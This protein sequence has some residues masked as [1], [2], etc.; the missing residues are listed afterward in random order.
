MNWTRILPSAP[1]GKR[2]MPRGG[3]MDGYFYILSG[4][5]G[6]FTVY[7]DTWRS[8]DGIHWEKMS[9]NTGWG[10]RCYPEVELIDGNII[11]IAGQSLNQ[12]YN[13][14][15]RSSD[16]GKTWKQVCA[17]APWG[18]RAGHHTIT[19]KKEIYLFGGARNS[20]DRIFYPELWVSKDLGETWELRAHLPTDMGRAGMQVVYI[21]GVIYF[22][23]GDHDKPVFLPN[24]AGRRNDIW[25]STDLGKTWQLIGHAPWS[26]RTGQQ[27]IA[28]NGKVICIGG[29]IQGQYK[30]KQ[31]LAHD[32][33]V[34]NPKNGIDDWKLISN[35]V[36]SAETNT[37]ASG[38]SDFLLEI[39]DNKIWTLGGDR[40]VISPY[41]QDNDVWVANLPTEIL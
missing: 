34:W 28:H 13:D 38:K 30:Y 20:R 18:V 29:H 36:W 33:W 12:F 27:C 9:A 32:L 21:D 39:H 31:L 2:A 11:L 8:P 1:W 10:K 22:M 24:W 41:P 25:K 5:A 3:F 15:W 40:E 26:P 23:G 16:G 17:N 4:R 14:V 7:S 19:I 6:M 37:R 35:N